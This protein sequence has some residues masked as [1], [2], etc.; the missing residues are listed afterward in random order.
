MTYLLG[1]VLGGAFVGGT[2]GCVLRRAR[3]FG[4]PRGGARLPSCCRV[5]LSCHLPSPLLRPP[6]YLTLAVTLPC[7]DCLSHPPIPALL[8]R[9]IRGLVRGAL[10]WQLRYSSLVCFTLGAVTF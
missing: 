3:A 9:F 2:G 1:R 8:P 6:F 7:A 10:V 5:L 4:L